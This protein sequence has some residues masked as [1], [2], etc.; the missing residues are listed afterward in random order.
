MG[1]P[2]P[3]PMV[4]PAPTPAIERLALADQL[5]EQFLRWNAAR[6]AIVGTVRGFVAS[7]LG[8]NLDEFLGELEALAKC[9]AE[10]LET[11]RALLKAAEGL[12]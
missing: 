3:P 7:P 12:G 6:N 4:P 5:R 2:K 8:R 10:Q 11:F 9:E 1:K